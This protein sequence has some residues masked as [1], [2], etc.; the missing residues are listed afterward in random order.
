MARPRGFE[1][2]TRKVVRR[3][4]KLGRNRA[5]GVKPGEEESSLTIYAT[6]TLKNAVINGQVNSI[7]VDA[8]VDEQRGLIYSM[9]L[10]M[11]RNSILANGTDIKL[12]PG[13]AVTAEVQTGKRRI[14][15][16]FLAP[17]LRHKQESLQER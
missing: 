12:M 3:N 5:G 7:S 9:H 4:K 2:L 13:M 10:A 17:L 11:E 14:I 16:F 1:P 6:I 15:E 8:I